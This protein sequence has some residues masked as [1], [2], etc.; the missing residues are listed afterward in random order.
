MMICKSGWCGRV[1]KGC[2]CLIEP[3]NKGY[4]VLFA[5]KKEKTYELFDMTMRNFCDW[6]VED[7]RNAYCKQG[8]L[9]VQIQKIEGLGYKK[10]QT[11]ELFKHLG[12]MIHEVSL[13]NKHLTGIYM[14][15]NQ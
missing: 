15:E 3:S 7:F 13:S 2:N 6:K 12:K 10:V 14:Y 4:R 1:V 5:N 9:D 8:E 11:K